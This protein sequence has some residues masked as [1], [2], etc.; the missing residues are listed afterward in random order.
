[1]RIYIYANVIGGNNI[2]AKKKHPVNSGAFVDLVCYRKKTI[3]FQK[4]VT[5]YVS[6]YLNSLIATASISEYTR[7]SPA[8]AHINP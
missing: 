6:Y 7:F 8:I 1:M 4:P 5:I 3:D 2:D